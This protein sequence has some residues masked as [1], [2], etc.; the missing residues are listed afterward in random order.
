M[1]FPSNFKV[2]AVKFLRKTHCK[3]NGGQIKPVLFEIQLY[4]PFTLMDTGWREHPALVSL[5]VSD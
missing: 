3:E 1:S 5:L 4:F 2:D